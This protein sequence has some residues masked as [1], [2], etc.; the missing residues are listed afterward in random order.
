MENLKFYFLIF[1]FSPLLFS[2]TIDGEPGPVGPPGP[3]GDQGDQTIAMEYEVNF[4]LKSSNDWSYLYSFPSQDEIYPEDVVLVYL[5]WDVDNG[6]DVWRLMPVSYFYDA[7]MLQINYDF[8]QYDVKIFADASF[9]LDSQL[10][11]YENMV[12]RIV[13]IP[14]DFSPNQRKG[15]VDYTNYEEIKKTYGLKEISRKTGQSLT[16]ILKKS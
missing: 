3:K 8:T 12:A 5:L 9:T 16:E 14:S 15:N 6:T 10:D 4:D 11:K 13:V 2:C 7:G 1:I